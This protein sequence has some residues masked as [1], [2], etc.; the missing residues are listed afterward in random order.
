M[1]VNQEDDIRPRNISRGR[2]LLEFKRSTGLLGLCSPSA[3]GE[4]VPFI[5]HVLLITISIAMTHGL[6]NAQ[7]AVPSQEATSLPRLRPRWVR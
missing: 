2:R 5:T 6:G 7:A 1:R 3:V 4:G